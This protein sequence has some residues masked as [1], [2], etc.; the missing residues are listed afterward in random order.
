METRP[1]HVVLSEADFRR[2]VSGQIVETPGVRIILS[3]IGWG[4]MTAAIRDAMSA[5]EH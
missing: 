3:D 4:R 5:K 1:I 2:L